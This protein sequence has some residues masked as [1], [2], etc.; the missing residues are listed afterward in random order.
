MHRRK[1]RVHHALVQRPTMP[2]T[3][4]I[5]KANKSWINKSSMRAPNEL[6]R[7][8]TKFAPYRS[9]GRISLKWDSAVNKFCH[10]IYNDS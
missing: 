3:I 6:D 5:G 8:H 2:W 9:R 4:R 10:S 7:P 1:N